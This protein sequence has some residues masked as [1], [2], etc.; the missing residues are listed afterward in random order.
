MSSQP[1]LELRRIVSNHLNEGG[2]VSEDRALS[3]VESLVSK[4]G[5]DKLSEANKALYAELQEK[6]FIS[7]D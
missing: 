4:H 6:G 5:S 2:L 7:H 1:R 3:V